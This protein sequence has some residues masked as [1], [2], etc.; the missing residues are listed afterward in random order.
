MKA[1]YTRF[2]LNDLKQI[3]K[4]IDNKN[5]T[6]FEA[7]QSAYKIAHLM[8]ENAKERTQRQSTYYWG[9]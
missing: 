5:I 1:Q 2:E 3:S 9:K 6:S 4:M 8:E 7:L